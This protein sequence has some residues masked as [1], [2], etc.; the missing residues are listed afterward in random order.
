MLCAGLIRQYAA[1]KQVFAADSNAAG[2][3]CHYD[4]LSKI[5]ADV[6]ML[7]PVTET[8]RR[9]LLRAASAAASAATGGTA[10]GGSASG[11]SAAAATARDAALAK[12]EQEVASERGVELGREG[13][14]GG[15]AEK[16]VMRRGL[17][18]EMA[19]D[20]EP[21]L[22]VDERE[23]FNDSHFWRLEDSSF[24]LDFV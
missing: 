22:D 24:D 1:P 14:A 10:G 8:A 2:S 18:V 21:Q 17:P 7:F 23:E 3:S 13:F 12:E 6:D 5:D 4:S 16:Q 11:R 19:G 20:G 15:G 9:R